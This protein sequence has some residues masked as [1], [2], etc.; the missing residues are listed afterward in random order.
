MTFIFPLISTFC[1]LINVYNVIKTRGSHPVFPRYRKYEKT[2][3]LIVNC[4]RFF[5]FHLF[6]I[7]LLRSNKSKKH[8]YLK[9]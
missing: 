1:A 6:I 8:F 5:S 7:F 3:F 9:K 2:L 4:N